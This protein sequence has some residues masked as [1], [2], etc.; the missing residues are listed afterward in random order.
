VLPAGGADLQNVAVLVRV[1][2]QSS[3]AEYAKKSFAVHVVEQGSGQAATKDLDIKLLGEF[4][5]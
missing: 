3:A 1:R 5:L 4:Y 2:G